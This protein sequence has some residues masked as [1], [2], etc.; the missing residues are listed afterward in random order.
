M[1]IPVG[2]TGIGDSVFRGCSGLTNVTIPV[3]VTSIGDWAFDGC[4]GLTSVTIPNSVTSIGDGAFAGCSG[5]TSVTIPN[6][7]T[8]IGFMAFSGCRSLVDMTIPDGVASIGGRAFEDCIGLTNVTI[9][10][11]VMCIGDGWISR[12]FPGCR[13]LMAVTILDG[14]QNIG[15]YVF[16][17]CIGLTSVTIPSSVTNI[18]GRAFNG[19]SSLTNIVVDSG[20]PCYSSRNGLLLNKDGSELLWGCMAMS[21]FPA[22][23]TSIGPGAFSG[24]SGLT[25][26]TIPEGVK[27]IGVG[28]FAGC[29]GL[30]DMA[31]PN[32]VTSI[33]PGAFSG[34]SNLTNIT[35]DSGNPRYSSRDGLLLDKDGTILL[36]GVNGDVVIPDSVTSIG[37]SA[38]S[39]CSGLTSVTI[40]TGVT[41]IGEWAFSGCSGLTNVVVPAGV[42]H[43]GDYAFSGCRGLTNVEI[44][45]GV[46]SIGNYAFSGCSG[47]TNVEIP[48]G[49][50]SIGGYAFSGCSGLTNVEIPVGVTSIGGY[51]FSGCSGLTNVEIPVGVTSIGGYAFSGCSGLT[52]VEIPAGVTSIGNY[53]FSA[54]SGLTNM[55]IPAGVTSIGGY[56]FSGCSGLTNVVIPNSVT[57]MGYRWLEE[58]WWFEEGPVFCGCNSLTNI[59]VDSGNP[60]YSSRDGLLLEQDGTMLLQG[61]NGD[62]MIP[63]SVTSIG[64][65]AFSGCSG[66]TSVTIPVGVTG[67]GW[68]VF[69]GCVG[70]TNITVDAG[71]PNYSS[72]NGMLL[73]KDGGRLLC[74]AVINGA[75]EIP[76]GVTSIDYDAFH[77]HSGLTSVTIP[78][79]MTH[80]SGHWFHGCSSLTNITVDAGNPCYSSRNG[81]LLNKNGSKLVLGVNGDVVIPSGVTR[82]GYEAFDGCSGL[83]SVAIP[84]GVTRIE[85]YA[86]YDCSGLTS[87]TIPSSVTYIGHAAFADCSGLVHVRLPRRFERIPDLDDEDDL[88]SFSGCNEDL[89]LDY[90]DEEPRSSYEVAVV[91]D[92]EQ[93]TVTGGGTYAAG[94]KVVLKATAKKGYVFAGWELEGVALPEGADPQDPVLALVAGGV[95]VAATA[96]FIPVSEDWAEVGVAA[97]SATFAEEY[98]AGGAFAPVTLAARGG[99]RATLKVTGLPAGLKFTA[100]P[101]AVR[102]PKTKKTAS[103]PANTVYG[104]PT[105]SG[106]Y[107]VAATATTAGG[108]TATARWTFAVRRAGERVVRTAGE[109]A[110]G[111]VSGRGVYAKGRKVTLKATARKG[112]V[113]A[114]WELEG[115]SLPKGADPMN[116]A[117]TITVGAADITAT[118]RF[119]PV[120]EDWAEVGVADGSAPFAEEYATG[121][122]FAPVTLAFAG[123]SR[124]TVKVAGLPA[125]LKFTAKALAVRDPKTKKTTAYLAN[126]IYGKP[127]KSGIY[128][129]TAKVATAGGK[130]ATARWTFTVRKPGERAVWTA[131]DAARGVVSGRGVYAK[132]K[133]VTLKATAKKGY[134]FAG[135]ELEG[136][137]LPKGFDARTPVLA[138]TPGAADV[139]ATARFAPASED[140]ALT[141]LVD[142]AAVAADG[143][144]RLVSGGAGFTLSVESASLPKLSLSGLPAGLKFDAKSG[145]ITGRGTKPGLYTVT[146]RLS[147]ATVRKAVARRFRIEVPNFTAANAFLRDGLANA[148][149]EAYAAY[150]G[151]RAAG[152]PTLVPADPAH[153][154]SMKV[155][156]LPAGLRFDAKA[157]AA[158]EAALAGVPAKAGAYTVAVS[159]A[160]R[161]STFTLEVLPLPDWAVGTFTGYFDETGTDGTALRGTAAFTVSSAGKVSAKLVR[162]DGK[163]VNWT[164]A[165]LDRAEADAAGGTVFRVDAA[166]GGFRCGVAISA[167]AREG[168]PAQ[169]ALAGTRRP[170]D[171]GGAEDAEDGDARGAG[172]VGVA[173]DCV[174]D[175]WGRGR[176]LEGLA[177]KLKGR[178]LALPALED[179]LG[180]AYDVTLAFGANGAVTAKYR[181]DGGAAQ[182]ASGTLA[183]RGEGVLEAG[184]G[185]EEAGDGGEDGEG[186]AVQVAGSS[187]SLYLNLVRGGRA[188]LEV[189]LLVDGE[190]KVHWVDGRVAGVGEP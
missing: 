60:R 187:L 54:C 74:A 80:I 58:D 79:G 33:G 181:L 123:G 183:Y 179:G 24:C 107:T 161:T 150:V 189:G 124:A 100:K 2:V 9:P 137:S 72:Q 51:A 109:T 28:A 59:T 103:Y 10:G 92:V 47:L 35:V 155:T 170:V 26:V 66:L 145:R 3:G 43:I 34:C 75:A 68:K 37:D 113:F 147:N 87:M 176:A 139:T 91:Y 142:G 56:A 36:R 67:I 29:S 90:Y 89:V 110:R 94:K 19:C 108:K 158:G 15:D 70:L 131:C 27:S 39:G 44:P 112:Y 160:G 65:Y 134:V 38:F 32:C 99:S 4:S 20:N 77:G 86:F 84:D 180:H 88:F 122:A 52:N 7:V 167:A 162:Q 143:S 31:I 141:L 8:N 96:R 119:I 169:G 102:D 117:L 76:S 21:R 149:G 121:G 133:K 148:P 138:F 6:G 153:A 127:T 146:A 14:A 5:L 85:D 164:H 78:A 173:F 130:T 188:F 106:L 73:T 151:V 136:A 50:T 46:T 49:V 182:S 55:E 171:A 63:D 104:T 165:C 13:N 98:V 40:P 172:A 30:T 1:T 42:A 174:Q 114:G 132:G 12:L 184:D 23:V 16:D 157:A 125:G 166:V 69:E 126:T 53:A 177:A 97:G 83:T 111:T 95:D 129:V 120:S 144:T 135:W 11:S 101:L 190:G 22:G 61:V 81:L 185:E 178:R 105:K 175:L 118:A 140:R 115:A 156:G 163:S 159:V 116:P 154:K 41:S 128:T 45:V 25:S 64:S 82:I 48:A 71:N 17:D 186:E 18:G 57:R 168:G 93:G 62:V 152:L